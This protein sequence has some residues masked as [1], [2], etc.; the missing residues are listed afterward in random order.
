M[1]VFGGDV[2]FASDIN[3]QPKIIARGQ[4]TTATAAITTTETGVI[5]LD[6]VPVRN[7]Y[8]YEITVD[9]INIDTSVANDIGIVRMRY[10]FAASAGSTATT[11]STQLNTWRNTIDDATNSN[12]LPWVNHYF[13]TA[14]GFLSIL[15]SL[16]RQAGTG[17]LIWFCSA[18]DVCNVVVKD[19]GSDPGNTGVVI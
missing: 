11:T 1:T 5:R 19:I 18:T 2:I 16:Q 14:D 6:D 17:N 13:A 8:C 10:V 7:G 3:N 4:R 9:N 15:F 12:V